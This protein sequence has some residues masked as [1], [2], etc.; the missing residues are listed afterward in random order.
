MLS[1]VTLGLLLTLALAN[2]EPKNYEY[3]KVFRVNVPTKTHFDTLS[4]FKVQFW[5]EGRVGGYA[6][7]MV[8]PSDIAEVEYRLKVLNFHY[9][10]MV[11]NVGDLMRLEKVTNLIF[12]C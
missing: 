9:S 5:N 12:N 10:T 1:K 3:Y 4:G 8:A 11:E 6:D 7:V 2:A